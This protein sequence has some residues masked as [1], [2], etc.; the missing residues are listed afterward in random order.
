MLTLEY[1]SPEQIKGEVAST[2]SDIYSLGVILY[3]LLCGRWPYWVTSQSTSDVL[4][5]ICE[6]LPEKPS[7]TITSRPASRPEPTLDPANRLS[8]GAQEIARNRGVSTRRLRKILTGDLDSIVSMALQKEPDRR[9]HSV[10]GFATDVDAYLS[11]RPVQSRRYFPTYR[12]SKFIARHAITVAL[13]LFSLLLLM[14]SL[15][16][17]TR[18]LLIA[19]HERDRAREVIPSSS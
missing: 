19:R 8:P 3:R 10:E 9:Y 5:A 4:Q 16:A 17:L 6:Q 13:G 14:T 18:G 7:V 12:T 15:I 11:G 1:T 2:A